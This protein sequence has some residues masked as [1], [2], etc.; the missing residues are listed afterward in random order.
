MLIKMLQH[1]AN[2][3]G[4]YQPGT[5]IEVADARGKTLCEDGV[6]EPVPVVQAVSRLETATKVTA[7]AETAVVHPKRCKNC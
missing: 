7:N 4:N 5:V 6:A 3:I 2:A 1:L